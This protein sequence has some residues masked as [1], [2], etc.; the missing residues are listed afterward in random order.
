VARRLL[1]AGADPDLKTTAGKSPLSLT[2]EN[3][4]L[5][6][7]KLLLRFGAHPYGEGEYGDSL[8]KVAIKKND[9]NALSVLLKFSS[10]LGTL[11]ISPE[12]FEL[13]ISSIKNGKADMVILKKMLKCST[14]PNTEKRTDL[15]NE[16]MH[17]AEELEA[18]AVAA[19]L[20]SLGANDRSSNV[21][22]LR[23]FLE[24]SINSGN[25]DMLIKILRE[26]VRSDFKL[27]SGESV[28]DFA[29]KKGEVVMARLLLNADIRAK[30]NSKSGH[31]LLAAAI[32][33]K[34]FGS[35]K[36]LMR[37]RAD[38]DVK[39]IGN[40]MAPSLLRLAVFEI[41]SGRADIGLLEI[42]TEAGENIREDAGGKK[43]LV[44][45]AR[46]MQAPEIARE[47]IRLGA[48]GKLGSDNEARRGPLKRTSAKYAQIKS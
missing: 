41:N 33:E 31:H 44:L 17:M 25:I 43:S 39:G 4:N 3:G 35:L 23:E 47:L 38:P 19:V 9:L 26:G 30:A 12:E 28:L 48:T 14:A 24:E 2:I 18:P 11:N 1:R 46:Y 5:Q 10:D 7:S 37:E 16:L 34:D 8:I 36:R 13:A 27:S 6:M 22:R 32:R 40:G 45:L 20:I 42:L 15:C 29:L 21:V